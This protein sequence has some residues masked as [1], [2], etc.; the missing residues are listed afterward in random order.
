MKADAGLEGKVI[1]QIL[2]LSANAQIERRKT[3]RDSAA[4]HN[5]TGEIIAYGKAIA[6]LIAVRR[7]KKL[8]TILRELNLPECVV[9]QIH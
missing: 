5:L 7:Q 1:E 4:F 2:E 9:A 3:A 8:C 6:L